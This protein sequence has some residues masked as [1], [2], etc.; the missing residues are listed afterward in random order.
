MS[1]VQTVLLWRTRTRECCASL[2]SSCG[3]EFDH[4]LSNNDSLEPLFTR[5]TTRCSADNV[6]LGNTFGANLQL[7]FCRAV[8]L[9]SNFLSDKFDQKRRE[10]ALISLTQLIQNL[11]ET[12]LRSLKSTQS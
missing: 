10:V 6:V 11:L 2:L 5:S 7:Q 12:S 4:Y 3:E 1:N 8:Q 9:K